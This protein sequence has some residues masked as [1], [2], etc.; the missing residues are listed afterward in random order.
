MTRNTQNSGSIKFLA[1]IKFKLGI[2]HDTQRLQY[3]NM[4]STLK[5]CY[6]FKL[7]LVVDTNSR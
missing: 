5:E 2:K 1:S 6:C 7:F 3:Y 4:V